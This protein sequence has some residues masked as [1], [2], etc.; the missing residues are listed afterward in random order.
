M[1]KQ[2]VAVDRYQGSCVG[3]IDE[4]IRWLVTRDC[5]YGNQKFY[6]LGREVQPDIKLEYIDE[7]L[8]SN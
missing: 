7:Q 8:D 1:A 3:S 4:I 2:Y 5:E 6:E